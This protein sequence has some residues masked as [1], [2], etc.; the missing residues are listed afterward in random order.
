MT[1]DVKELASDVGQ[2]VLDTIAQDADS[3]GT[4][5]VARLNPRTKVSQGDPV[6]LVVDTRRLH[7]FD[8][9]NGSGIYQ[10]DGR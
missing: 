2:E 9:D 10:E 1:E 5:V 6:E 7:F 3:E 8:L 4:N